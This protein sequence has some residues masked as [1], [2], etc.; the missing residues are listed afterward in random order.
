MPDPTPVYRAG[1]SSVVLGAAASAAAGIASLW[2]LNRLLGKDDFGGYAFAMNAVFLFAIVATLGLDR[3]VLLRVAGL[4]GPRGPLRGTAMARQAATA[5]SLASLGVILLFL[6][7]SAAIP[8]ASGFW[9]GALAVVILP[10]ALTGLL[11]AWLQA[12]HRTPEAAILSAIADVARAALLGLAF[13]MAA[14]RD[15]VI[16]AVIL[17][18]CTPLAVT[19][20]RVRSSE[21]R[22]LPKGLS[23]SDVAAGILLMLQNLSVA[24][25]RYIDLFLLGLLTTGA[26]TADYAVAGRL[27]AMA[28]LGRLS[29]KSTFTPRVRRHL[30]DGDREAIARE[31]HAL[32]LAAFAFAMLV[33]AVF[34]VFGLPILEFFGPY[35]SAY[36]PLLLLAAVAVLAAGTGM[37][38]SYLVM[39]GEVA[40]SAG[41]RVG[42][43]AC[44]AVAIAMAAPR[45]GA[46]GAA[47]AMLAVQG[48][49][50]VL[51]VMLLRRRAGFA[52]VR[53]AAAAL[54]AL[55]VAALSLGALGLLHPL[56]VGA[57]LLGVTALALA[58]EREAWRDFGQ[59]IV[60][61]PGASGR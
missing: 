50:N 15:G 10:V 2:L 44:L 5:V 56:A 23:R 38:S 33:A 40:W 52:A 51:A 48:V 54:V 1:M 39:S 49:V 31:F 19:A 24:G 4:A 11:R 6:L 60:S 41:L 12:N 36:G 25:M 29:L 3:A 26:I 13:L 22:R 43:L 34:A 27:A 53:P 7:A 16:A 9:M 35:A 14:G 42:S 37:H 59:L 55:S 32:R 58:L 17:G 21:R 57:A 46:L 18:A 8:S 30:R 47:F 61:R 45:H 20:L 28:D